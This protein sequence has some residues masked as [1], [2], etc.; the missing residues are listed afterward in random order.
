M[1]SPELPKF[2]ESDKYTSGITEKFCL[3]CGYKMQHTEEE[4]TDL[5]NFYCESTF[6]SQMQIGD[7]VPTPYGYAP[8]IGL[9][10]HSSNI[11]G[12]EETM[13]YVYKADITVEYRANGLKYWENQELLAPRLITMDKYFSRQLTEVEYNAIHYKTTGNCGSTI[14]KRYERN[15]ISAEQ[16]E[17]EIIHEVE[18]DSHRDTLLDW[19]NSI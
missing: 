4:H 18:L 16:I 13:T 17:R 7:L 12:F 6:L 5:V 8:L 11:D 15:I 2:F 19:V 14:L 9:R 10:L 3:L 1:K